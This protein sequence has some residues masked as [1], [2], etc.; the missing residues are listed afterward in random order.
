MTVTVSKMDRPGS[1]AAHSFLSTKFFIPQARQPQDVLPRPRLIE[2][3]Q[4]GLARKLTLISAPAGYGKTMLLAEWM[5]Q[6]ER[7]V[8]W[9]S[10]DETD[11]D[12][13]RFLTYFIAALQRLKTDF[14]QA[15]LVALQS[16]QPPSIERL[17]TALV[18]EIIP[19][20]PFALVLDDYHLIQQQAI[21]TAIAFMLNHLPSNMHLI[22]TSRA[23]PP[24]PLARLRVREQMT[25]LRAADLRFTLDEVTAF[26][27]QVKELPL[28]A[29]QIQELEMRTEGWGAA[30]QLAALSLQGLDPAAIIRFIGDF[31]GSHHNVFD[32]LVE[33]VLRQQPAEI[34]RFLLHTSILNRLCSPLCDAILSGE[35]EEQGGGG[36]STIHAAG[37]EVL[38]YLEH[39]NL[40]LVPLDNRRH[41]Y[42]Y[43]HLFAELLRDRL[44]QAHPSNVPELHRRA[45][46][47]YEHNGLTAEAVQHALAAGAFEQAAHLIEQMWLRTFSL[48]PLQHTLSSWLASLP[49]EFV[50]VR[51]KLCLIHAWLSLQQRDLEAALRRLEEAEQALQ[52]QA[53]DD[54]DDTR[55]TQG[56]ITATRMLVNTMSSHFD[57]GRVKVWA[58]EALEWLRPDN[59]PYRGVVFGALAIASLHQGDVARAEQAFAEAA[60]ISR[61]IGNV[62][63]TLAAVIGQTNMQRA[64][65]ALSLALA[66]CQQALDWV[67]ELGAEASPATGGI[68]L[69]LAEILRERNDLEGA[70]H[71][72]TTGV[73]RFAQGTSQYLIATGSLIVARIKQAQGHSEDAFE[74]MRQ[75]R[76]PAEQHQLAW[77]FTLLPVIETQL[78]LAQG[79]LPARSWSPGMDWEKKLLRQ[80][81]GHYAFIYAYEYGK[82]T[83]AQVMLAHGRAAADQTLL[84]EVVAQLE[85]Q[86]RAAQ[87]AGLLWLQMKTTALQALAYHALGDL[88]S[89]LS[90]LERA[91]TLARPEGYVRL[92]VDEGVPMAQ[93]LVQAVRAG[94][95]P[96]Y[97]GQLLA[98]FPD[99]RFMIADF[100]LGEEPIQSAE[101]R[102]QNRTESLS[103]RDSDWAS[104]SPKSGVPP[105]PQNLIEPLSKRELEILS[106][107]AQ[108]LTNTEIAQ[109]IYI[110]D[111]TV[112]V[113][114]RNIYGKLGVNS[115]RQAVTKARAL[116]LL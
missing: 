19:L 13:T 115:R 12:L 93:L 109:Q 54:L 53:N 28:A 94:L 99:F 9:L 52:Q 105:G 84:R 44:E 86:C 24:L 89:A 47:W 100:R 58:Q 3:L 33:E 104:Q 67:T 82:L 38:A 10:L 55:N 8:A 29:E 25:E 57:P 50:R 60:T 101:S 97:A 69:N 74:L 32:Y 20:D 80:Y 96:D 11:N 108:S 26:F 15:L 64:R 79:D 81:P 37:R 71:Y 85:Q 56:E 77:L 31:T 103:K 7:R 16:P 68:Y 46:T 114:T 90:T 51:P 6:I 83:Q 36:E 4:A 63:V 76:Q 2:R 78:R 73:T 48:D 102:I 23:D 18:N 65:G 17:T 106:L 95:L 45:S 62:Y 92:F 107:L 88:A 43:H 21:H 113:H 98:A 49:V 70:L 39:A 30:L 72:A 112:K 111:Q 34:H 59:A 91:L 22:L 61:G 75:L 5:P 41:W 27:H 1:P 87:T 116:G 42:R 14:G 35:G 110:S 40:F 66:T